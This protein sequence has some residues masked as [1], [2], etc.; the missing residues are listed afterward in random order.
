MKKAKK[1]WLT[2]GSIVALLLCAIIFRV[3]STELFMKILNVAAERGSVWAQYEL[4]YINYLDRPAHDF[5]NTSYTRDVSEA[6]KWLSMA[7]NNG[8]A[9]AQYFLGIAYFRNNG[10][11]RDNVQ[12]LRWLYKASQQGYPKAKVALQYL[13]SQMSSD[14]IAEAKRKAQ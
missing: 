1:L 8:D 6:L 4:G 10:F 13:E 9:E 7:A 11:P 3:E 5:D 2:L 12:A 14:V